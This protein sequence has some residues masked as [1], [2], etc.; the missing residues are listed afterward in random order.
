[1]Y[2]KLYRTIFDGS[3]YGQFE[4]LAVFMAMLALTD[5][6]GDVDV[7]P[8]KIAGSLG[9][10]L[11]FVERGIEALMQP[12]PESRTPK[13]DGRRIVPLLNDEDEPRPFGWRIVNYGKYR[14]IRNEEERRAYKRDWARNKRA[15]QRVADDVDSGQESTA[16]DRSG[17]QK[18]H[19][20]A[21]ADTEVLRKRTLSSSIDRIFARWQEVHRH[22][23]AKLTKGRRDLIRRRLT[24]Y[25]EDDLIRSI[26]GYEHSTHHSG[27]NDRSTRYDSIELM[28]RDAAHIEAGWGFSGAA[29]GEEWPWPKV[30]ETAEIVAMKYDGEEDREIFAARV[31]AVN[32]RRIDAL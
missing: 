30:L 16:V 31:K 3:L 8:R 10:P 20:E 25:S 9:C 11:D 28:L 21:E 26:E 23:G 17:P 15:A 1:M 18:T 13:E 19:T 2:S 14:S 32:Q 6:H 5:Q 29:N 27:E 22:P 12:D 7:S 4:P 24:E